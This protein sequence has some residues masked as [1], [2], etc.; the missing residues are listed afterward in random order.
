MQTVDFYLFLAYRY[1]VARG[2]GDRVFRFR[3]GCH[4]QKGLVSR[5]DGAG[6]IPPEEH[7]L[8]QTAGSCRC[9]LAVVESEREGW[10]YGRIP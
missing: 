9:P 8:R 10:E 2:H 4:S 3:E 7:T 1:A 5:G 6:P